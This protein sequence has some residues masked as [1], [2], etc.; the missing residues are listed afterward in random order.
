MNRGDRGRGLIKEYG[1]RYVSRAHIVCATKAVSRYVSFSFGN[2][3]R[4]EPHSNE[5]LQLRD[6]ARPRRETRR[7]QQRPRV[8]RVYPPDANNA[9]GTRRRVDHCTLYSPRKVGSAGPVM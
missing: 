8:Y 4:R 7:T 3:A 9:G 1:I 2:S 5:R 6:S